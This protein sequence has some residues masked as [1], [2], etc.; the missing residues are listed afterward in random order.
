M[1]STSCAH[2]HRDL[3]F[4]NMTTTP[5]ARSVTPFRNHNHFIGFGH[6]H[7]SAYDIAGSTH[8][9]HDVERVSAPPT[10]AIPIT[11]SAPNAAGL[12]RRARCIAAANA[13]HR[14]RDDDDLGRGPHRPWC[15]V[16]SAEA[17]AGENELR[18]G[19]YVFEGIFVLAFS[20]AKAGLIFA[21]IT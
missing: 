20:R 4:F 16:L 11:A 19:S 6:L 1:L 3:T 14:H 5:R 12:W 10:P 15:I 18:S 9:H 13:C 2:N 7:L 8:W 21:F 17:K